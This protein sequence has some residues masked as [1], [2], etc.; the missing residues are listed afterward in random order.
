[1]NVPHHL[2]ALLACTALSC[3]AQG[4]PE[5][6]IY[7]GGGRTAEHKTEATNHKATSSLGYLRLSSASDW[8]WGADLGMEGS[9]LATRWGTTRQVQQSKPYNALL[10]HNVQRWEDA[11]LD[12]MLMVGMRV[13]TKPCPGPS[14]GFACYAN[15]PTEKGR[16]VNGGVLITYTHRNALIGLRMNSVS[17][18]VVL[19]VLF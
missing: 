5:N 12:A 8:V 15:A 6:A 7:G 18:Q 14:A 16:E 10:G 11:R 3:L 2:S 17:R 9:L 1:M 13:A 19:G 4:L